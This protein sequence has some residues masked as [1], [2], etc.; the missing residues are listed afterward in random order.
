MENSG[1]DTGGIWKFP[2]LTVEASGS[3]FTVVS[4][5]G[6]TDTVTFRAL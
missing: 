1:E 4:P 3:T 5:S 2:G 6:K